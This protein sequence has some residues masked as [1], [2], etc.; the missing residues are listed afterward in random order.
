MRLLLVLLAAHLSVAAS[1]QTAAATRTAVLSN[2]ELPRDQHGDLI[3]TGE[4]SALVHTDSA[5][6]QTT[7]YFYFNN[8]GDCPGVDCCDSPSGCASCCFGPPF[9]HAPPHPMQACSN[10]YLTNHTVQGYSTTDLKTWTNMGVALP[11]SNRAPGI[12]FRPC[13][14]YN[15]ATGLF[16]MWY[17]DRGSGESGYAVAQSPTPAGPFKTTH[18]N[19]AMPGSGRIGDFNIFVDPADGVAYH[20]RTGF[21]IVKLDANFTGPAEH[22]ASFRTPK[23]SEGPTLF[24]RRGTYYITAGTGCCA[25]IGGSTIYVLSA[26]S[27]AGPWVYQGDVGSNPDHPFDA[28]SPDNYVTK[29]QGSAAFAVGDDIVYLGNQ[30]NSGLKQTPPGPRNHDLLYWAVLPFLSNGSIAQLEYQANVTVTL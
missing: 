12:E 3:I 21:D 15:K 28:H 9:G 29:A 13:V 16:V 5:S 27:P 19:V 6:G 8:W 24:K 25:C 22:V 18:R 14:V 30:W 1:K 2:T 7:Y 23:A 17:E 26:P 10:P 11:L 20:V 4:A